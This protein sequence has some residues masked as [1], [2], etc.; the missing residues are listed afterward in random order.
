MFVYEE[1]P[2]LSLNLFIL[3]A[4]AAKKFKAI[5]SIKLPHTF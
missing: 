5:K 4:Q 2:V 3:P 1:L